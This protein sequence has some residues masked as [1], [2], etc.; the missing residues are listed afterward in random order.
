MVGGTIGCGFFCVC[1][2]VFCFVV[3]CRLG[4]LVGS[5]DAHGL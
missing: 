2:W 3:M 5:W 4:E 1:V